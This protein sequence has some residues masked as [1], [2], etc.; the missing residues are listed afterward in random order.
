MEL[1]AG[2]QECF[3]HRLVLDTPL[4][5]PLPKREY[6][7]LRLR[8][9]GPSINFIF[10]NTSIPMCVS[11][12]TSENPPKKITK[13][14]NNSN[15]IK[16]YTEANLN[17]NQRTGCFD[18]L[19]KIAVEELTSCF[20]NE[21]IFMAVSPKNALTCPISALVQPFILDKVQ[22]KESSTSADPLAAMIRDID[23]LDNTFN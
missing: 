11:F 3:T 7:M 23:M 4:T 9:E 20:P 1:L 6:F 2:S 8:L 12:F 10:L 5:M 14:S 16:G 22:V 21:W 17:Y 19:F 18:V 13:N 15:C